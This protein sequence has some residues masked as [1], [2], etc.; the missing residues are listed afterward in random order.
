[1]IESSPKTR[2]FYRDALLFERLA[3]R[4][5][6]LC[7]DLDKAPERWGKA[8][9]SQPQ[10]IQLAQYLASEAN[11]PGSKIRPRVYGIAA[12]LLL[13]PQ[14]LES[15]YLKKAGLLNTLKREE[16]RALRD[17]YPHESFDSLLAQMNWS[18]L[19]RPMREIRLDT[20]MSARIV[21]AEQTRSGPITVRNISRHGLQLWTD[22]EIQVNEVLTLEVKLNESQFTRLCAQV[23]WKDE[24]G[25]Y[26]L[27]IL[28]YSAEWGLM[29][30][31]I[32]TQ[33]TKLAAVK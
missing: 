28:S 13:T 25:F 8:Y 15:L 29:V 7:L 22:K 4:S 10:E 27:R 32:E 14:M 24:S 33:F 1:V 30:Q 9:E 2:R 23:K 11:H 19:Q 16:V 31:S 3:I 26:G 20:Q 21:E 5:S 17:A 18:E 6:V 12:D